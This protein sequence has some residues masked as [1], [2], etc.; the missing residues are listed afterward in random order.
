MNMPPI[1]VCPFCRCGGCAV[2]PSEYSACKIYP[3]AFRVECSA[4]GA[5]GPEKRSEADA[6]AVW[7]AANK[8]KASET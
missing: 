7:N 3:C 1:R 8:D 4:C 2:N 6:V 5:K